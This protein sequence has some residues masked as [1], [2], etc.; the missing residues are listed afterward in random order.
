MRK[1]TQLQARHFNTCICIC[2]YK[3]TFILKKR[4]RKKSRPKIK[5]IRRKNTHY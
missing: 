5:K 2:K 3:H 1:M 4:R